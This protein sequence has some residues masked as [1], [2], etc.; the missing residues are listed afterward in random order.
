MEAEILLFEPADVRNTGN[1]VDEKF[2]A[3]DKIRI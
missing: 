3:P 2:T 1:V